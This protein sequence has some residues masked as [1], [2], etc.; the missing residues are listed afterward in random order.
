MGLLNLGVWIQLPTQEASELCS[1]RSWDAISDTGSLST[2]RV[3]ST[4]SL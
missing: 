2:F 1:V 4:P 3:S